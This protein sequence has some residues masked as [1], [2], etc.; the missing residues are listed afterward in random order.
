ME[1]TKEERAALNEKMKNPHKVVK[2]P[3]CGAELG[4][5][6]FETAWSV[7]CPTEGCISKSLRGI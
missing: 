6:A 5:K 4:Y 3:R 2:C 7:R 1:L